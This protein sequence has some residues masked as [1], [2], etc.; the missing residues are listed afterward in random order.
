MIKTAVSFLVLLLTPLAVLH[1]AEIQ[2]DSRVTRVTVYQDQAL[3]VRKATVDLQKGANTVRF[4]G[5][6]AALNEDSLRAAGKGSVQVSIQGV[7]LVRDFR[8]DESS[9]ALQ[10][11]IEEVD[12]L[13]DEIQSLS[14]RRASLADQ[15]RFFDSIRDFSSV[16]IPKEIVT[17][18][19]APSEWSSLSQQLLQSYT[20]NDAQ[21]MALEKDVRRTRKELEAKER[22]LA[23][24]Q[25]GRTADKNDAAV[26]IEAKGA[27]TLELELSYLL[28]QA[29]WTLSYEA[30]TESKSKNVSLL[31]FGNVRQWTGE[32]WQEAALTLSS[33]RPSVGGRMPE[34]QPWF[35]DFP[36]PMPRP[37]GG[38][39]LRKE[40]AMFSMAV[41]DASVSAAAP[42]AMEY[43]AVAK[44]ASVSQ[45]LGSVSYT[46]PKTA[47]VTADN[48]LYKFQVN[49]EEFPAEAG[50]QTTPKLSPEVYRHA[51]VKNDKDHALPGGEVGIFNDGVF[52]GKS[53]IPSTGRG[54]TFDLFLGVTDHVKVKRTE[55]ADKRKK[56]MLG[57]KAKREYAYRI[58]L[59]NY[60]GAEAK[61][62]VFDQ[63]PVSKNS[64]IK[65]DLVSADPK[66]ES[67]DLGE[68]QWNL[69]LPHS[70]KQAIEFG[71]TVE[72]PAHKDPIL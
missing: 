65:V 29:G 27:G 71:F 72:H 57:I 59:E 51:K 64:D 21:M 25:S 9:P 37:M 70:Q 45:D 55:L 67:N 17:K 2:A 49:S 28:P 7:Q 32:D 54:E 18:S 15:R 63:I 48:R 16:Q 36:Q 34:I 10:K 33:A 30:R 46:L 22:E 68:L 8:V 13:R 47:T 38:G 50:Y 52:V 61:V 20:E 42:Q 69:T 56:S 26:E 35:V 5:L 1:A 31:L 6:P 53:W 66:P 11:L 40:E 44:L 24:L 4:G 12:A 62:T 19:P 60:S 3:V 39:A 43:E 14:Q 23:E 58:E 41:M